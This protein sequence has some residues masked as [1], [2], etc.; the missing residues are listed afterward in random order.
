MTCNREPKKWHGM[1]LDTGQRACSYANLAKELNISVREVRTAINH[2]KSTH[3]VTQEATRGTTQEAT[4]EATQKLIP[5][6]SVFTITNW[7]KY[8][9]RDTGSDTGSDT[10]NDTRCDTPSDKSATNQR[11]ISDKS[12]TTIQDIENK[13]SRDINTTASTNLSTL[14][15]RLCPSLPEILEMTEERKRKGKILNSFLKENEIGWDTFL[16]RIEASD[17]LT[18]RAGNWN[19]C[20][21]DWV[22]DHY[23][24][25]VEGKYDN[26]ITKPKPKGSIS[27]PPSYSV[28]EYDDNGS[29]I[30][31]I[32]FEEETE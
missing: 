4:Q 12:A 3:D 20:D 17:L 26:R 29:W 2:L 27:A 21:F 23:V 15:K 30:D 13:R 6:C 14:W 5:K 10:G 22:L 24:K 11:Q 16:R 32:D 19:G 18:G 25:I 7:K 9:G 8:Q 28:S 1:V 31:N